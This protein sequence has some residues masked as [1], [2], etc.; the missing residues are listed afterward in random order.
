[1][2][3]DK[4]MKNTAQTEPSAVKITVDFFEK[5][6]SNGK[7]FTLGL[8]VAMTAI[9]FRDF[10][11]GSKV[12]L[13]KD[14]GSDTLNGLLPY[15][16]EITRQSKDML[17]PKWA[18]GSGMGANIFPLVFRDPFDLIIYQG[19]VEN[20]PHLI[21]IKEF[22]KIVLSGFLFYLFLKELNVK[23]FPALIGAIM[24]SFSGFM[25]VGGCWFVFSFEGFNMMLLMYGYQRFE[26]RN[27][28]LWYIVAVFLMFISM[29]VNLFWYGLF[30]FSF[31]LL[32]HYQSHQQILH[33]SLYLKL[34]RLS[35]L[36]LIGILLSGPVFLEVLQMLLDSPRGSGEDSYYKILSKQSKLKTVSSM[37]LGTSV[38]RLFSS[39]MLGGGTNYRGHLNFLEAPMFYC[40]LPC[41]LLMPQIFGFLTKKVKTGFIIFMTIWLLPI[42]FPYLRAAFWLFSG[43]YYRAYSF[44]VALVFII[45]S[46]MALDKILQTQKINRITLIVSA[47]LVF[48][49]ISY[50]YFKDKNTVDFSISMFV[51]V[52]LVAY[53]LIMLFYLPKP[54]NRQTAL[55]VFLGVFVLE[56]LFLSNF[57][58]NKRSIVSSGELK[59]KVGYNDYSIEAVKFVKDRESD[60]TFYRIDKNYFSTPAIHGSLNDALIHN[61]FGTSCYQSFSQKN[62]IGYLKGYGVI[63][64]GNETTSR[65]APGLINRPVL[66]S[67]NSVK[68]LMIRNYS[69]PLWRLT[70]DS[71]TQFGDVK[72][73]QNKYNIPFGYTYDKFITTSEFESLSSMQREYTSLKACV[74]PDNESNGLTKF[75]LKDTVAFNNFSFDV[76]KA[77]V[78]NLKADTIQLSKLENNHL[79][80]S[81]TSSKNEMLCLSIPF[82]A[83]WK[84]TVDGKEAKLSLIN[85]GLTGIYLEKGKHDIELNF[86][87]SKFNRGMMMVIAGIV[88]LGLCFVFRNKFFIDAKS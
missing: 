56:A 62:Y 49:L 51:K 32:R 11:S 58:I 29:P 88:L 41:L 17:F 74:V 38:M 69:N 77:G 61:Y 79:K 8:L 70:H 30:L 52:F 64:K 12:F 5:M 85:S 43:D 73:L 53:F 57:S 68:Y 21:F 48:I 75:D 76:Y 45:F 84:A 6:G 46:V 9:L 63:E 66:Q 80:G 22:L 2:S 20:V 14:I 59:Q 35:M 47:V 81:I 39:D 31:I 33:K 36:T 15:I 55:F 13:F 27:K 78:D 72:V 23:N 3:K 7:W 26:N 24:V 82:D 87:L 25:I 28:W 83:G 67:L 44:L 54:E 60:N 16:T 86:S 37:E 4:A 18:F 71:L 34:G 1:M 19:S 42:L 50:P 40:G 10:I 65:W